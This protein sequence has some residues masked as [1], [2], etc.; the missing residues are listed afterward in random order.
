MAHPHAELIEGAY[1]SFSRGDID[2]LMATWT[3]DIVWHT[4]GN[5]PVAGDHA[6]R[7]GVATF[8]GRVVAQSAGTLEVELHAVLADDERAFSLQRSTASKDGEPLE[9]WTVL[10]FL[11]R[12]GRICEIW[13]FDFDQRITDRMFA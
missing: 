1:A 8:L 11:F 10:G 3:D 5:N 7:Q 2:A 13:S 6:G 9:S 12:D 4:A